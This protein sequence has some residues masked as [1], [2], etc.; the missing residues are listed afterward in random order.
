MIK[1][2]QD[3]R[4]CGNLEPRFKQPVGHGPL[5][6]SARFKARA[7][8]KNT[9]KAGERPFLVEFLDDDHAVVAT[10]PE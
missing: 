9:K 6:G 7:L 1:E 3:C 2:E 8:P 5:L 10:E 4:Q